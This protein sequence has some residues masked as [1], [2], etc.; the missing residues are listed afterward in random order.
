MGPLRV[1]DAL[2]PLAAHRW[3]TIRISGV[4]KEA[5]NQRR[6]AIASVEAEGRTHTSDLDNDGADV[7]WG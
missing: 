5:H 6:K 7:L 2:L 4:V 1:Y 3:E